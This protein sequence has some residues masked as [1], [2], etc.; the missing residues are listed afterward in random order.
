[1]ADQTPEMCKAGA[2]WLELQPSVLVFQILTV[3]NFWKGDNEAELIQ[4]I[5]RAKA[6]LSIPE[7]TL[8]KNGSV[9][10]K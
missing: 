8:Y 10:K 2:L 9:K 5:L 4:E 7:T 3:P 6:R 1:M